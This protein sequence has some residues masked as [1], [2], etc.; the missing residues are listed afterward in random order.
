MA[1]SAFLQQMGIFT[2]PAFLSL[3]ECIHWRSVA[4][5]TGGHE[6]PVYGDG[7]KKI[8]ENFRK[9]L[10]VTVD[11]SVRS[12]LEERILSLRGDLERHF[13]V[14]LEGIEQLHCLMYRPGDFF[15]MH[16][17]SGELKEDDQSEIAKNLRRRRVTI[18]IF[19]N[20]QND[21]TEP[22]EGGVLTLY[23]LMKGAAASTFGFPVDVEQP[24]LLI[25]FPSS[26]LH[27]VSQVTAGRRYSLVAWFQARKQNQNE[28]DDHHNLQ[29]EA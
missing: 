19:L 29:A 11:E 18:L 17:D 24:G 16:S 14:E 5:T 7:E 27:E 1:N 25:A 23:G 10:T 2:M 8:N 20:S 6:A 4:V 26:M 22:Y 13:G 3:E 28:H 15:Q 21:E 9:T 12:K